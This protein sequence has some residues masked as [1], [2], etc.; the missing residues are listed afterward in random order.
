MMIDTVVVVDPRPIVTRALAALLIQALPA[1]RIEEA[2]EPSGAPYEPSIA[3]VPVPTA[4][5]PEVIVGR[6]LGT[7]G[8]WE[9]L[10][11]G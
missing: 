2:A 5:R 3:L 6:A 1:H 10:A 11:W 9:V 8:V 4:D 7:S